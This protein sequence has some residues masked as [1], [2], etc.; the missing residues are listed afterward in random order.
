MTASA[1]D[2]PVELVP[3]S[4]DIDFDTS[5]VPATVGEL[6]AAL[7]TYAS[8][9]AT[10]NAASGIRGRTFLPHPEWVL[11]AVDGRAEIVREK[12]IAIGSPFLGMKLERSSDL[13]T[14]TAVWELRLRAP[15]T[16]I[17]LAAA[18][19]EDGAAIAR[20]V[21]AAG[22]PES[23]M[24]L[25]A[26]TDPDALATITSRRK[27]V[28]AAAAGQIPPM[29]TVKV[30]KILLDAGLGRPEDRS[31]A[32]AH[33][34]ARVRP[35]N[36]R[37]AAKPVTLAIRVEIANVQSRPLTHRETQLPHSEQWK[38]VSELYRE[39]AATWIPKA[40][41]AL[42]AAGWRV[43]FEA[44]PDP[45]KRSWYERHNPGF[46]V[47]RADEDTLNQFDILF[48]EARARFRSAVG[49]AF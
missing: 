39:H 15:K 12:D 29:S 40:K 33:G 42:E 13:L 48:R 9:T 3:F 7:A 1:A 46:Y 30:R 14:Y 31:I 10:L 18:P 17:A 47:T 6:S 44:D 8:L 34:G 32:P 21:D 22:D 24:A 16:A 19:A 4:R 25:A 26:L 23:L 35:V 5:A 27:A 2:M 45:K 41:A 36:I 11:R 20:L 28:N 38:V 43:V 37:Q 49:K